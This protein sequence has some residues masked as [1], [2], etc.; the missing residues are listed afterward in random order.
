MS[1]DQGP[2]SE[3]VAASSSRRL[4]GGLLALVVL[5]GIIA[6]AA[7]LRKDSESDETGA[8]AR[9]ATTAP[10]VKAAPSAT[11]SVIATDGDELQI[12]FEHEGEAPR[13]IAA[14]ATDLPQGPASLQ[15]IRRVGNEKLRADVVRLSLH[16]GRRHLVAVGD[17]PMRANTTVEGR[18]LE[19][20]TRFLPPG[21]VALDDH[22]WRLVVTNPTPD[23]APSTTSTPFSLS[24]GSPRREPEDLWLSAK[25]QILLVVNPF[26]EAVECR[27][28]GGGWQHDF[29]LAGPVCRFLPIG[30]AQSLKLSTR[31]LPGRELIEER[32][33]SMSEGLPLHTIGGATIYRWVGL[34]EGKC[35]QAPDGALSF[36]SSATRVR[37]PNEDDPAHWLLVSQHDGLISG[38]SAFVSDPPAVRGERGALT[39][40]AGI[41]IVELQPPTTLHDPIITSVA[42]DGSALIAIINGLPVD[43]I[44]GQPL[45]D[46]APVEI[47]RAVAGPSGLVLLTRTGSL[48]TVRDRQLVL[49]QSL[50]DP[51]WRLAPALGPEPAVWLYSGGGGSYLDLRLLDD[52]GSLV[53]LNWLGLSAV[54][55][56]SPTALLCA[57]GIHVDRAEI[58]E[59][60]MS[61]SPV[62]VLP[63]GGLEILSLADLDGRLIYSTRDAVHALQGSLV[64]PLVEGIG[65]QIY[66]WRNGLLVHDARTLRL[67]QLTGPALAPLAKTEESR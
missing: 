13:L 9:P 18:E 47:A 30:D 67:Y 5:A 16:S 41:K 63:E 56:V 55:P 36:L 37:L 27:V 53:Y 20:A 38:L 51:T 45:L 62:L 60:V 1:A 49:G 25:D 54:C 22:A 24:F 6:A 52:T 39:A 29:V 61:V 35:P 3:P 50:Y 31:L 65:G 21:V 15:I 7:L 23:A 46:A 4:L 28:E 58:S 57:S 34:N 11:L 66:S 10:P 2:I 44:T 8:A 17:A 48:A 12:W 32:T 43:F 19:L 14:E 33:L 42:T 64:V 59:G 26:A 40:Q